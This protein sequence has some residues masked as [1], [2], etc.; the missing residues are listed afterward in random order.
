MR[1]FALLSILSSLA[2]VSVANPE[3]C[4]DH[5]GVVHAPGE[6]GT[7]QKIGTAAKLSLPAHKSSKSSKSSSS[8][9][10]KSSSKHKKVIKHAKNSA[11]AKKESTKPSHSWNH[12]SSDSSSP[13][14]KKAIPKV[15]HSSTKTVI[16]G[17]NKAVDQFKNATLIPSPL[18]SAL[19]EAVNQQLKPT[20]V[21]TITKTAAHLSTATSTV[22][23]VANSTIVKL[24]PT[25]I[26]RVIT[27]NVT[28][29]QTSTLIT[30]QES[31]NAALDI[32]KAIDSALAAANL[33]QSSL[34]ASTYASLEACLSTVL[35]SGGL[36]EGYSCLT[37]SGKDGSELESTLNTILEQFV[38]ILPNTILS[39]IFDSVTPLLTTLLPQ[40][41]QVLVNQITDSIQ[42]VIA[43][44]SGSS[45]TALEQVSSCYADAVK[46]AGNSSTLA[47]FTK[48]GGAASTLETASKSVLQQFVGVLP[49]SLTTAVE[50]ILTYNLANSSTP[51]QKL[52]GQVAAQISNAINSVSSALSGNTVT[53]AE[54]LQSCA[55]EL[56]ATGNATLAEQCIKDS[57]AP[58]ISQTT[59]LSIAQQFQ[60]YLP[61]SFF[62]DL[63]DYSTPYI[64][65][66]TANAHNLTQAQL[67]SEL[68]KFFNNGTSYGAQYVT[69]ISEV[70]QC[71]T[72]AIVKT[73]SIEAVCPGPVKGCSLA[74]SSSS[75]FAKRSTSSRFGFGG[76]IR[77]VTIY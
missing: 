19:A 72:N 47:C 57:K 74:K 32:K 9:S 67:N 8:S 68:E 59:M 40:S 69:C 7:P 62:T 33:T 56:I 23:Q 43:S 71:V 63:V 61:S 10:H 34:S 65:N 27:Q 11:T 18:A 53:L 50:N 20:N 52:A 21:A 2:L 4:S 5:P 75:R 73:G 36:P 45:V 39:A 48:P 14:K 41:E 13:K 44:L 51:D 66:F 3:P 1:S 22:T 76:S 42:S 16:D 49:A 30:S 17:A 58:Q 38:G 6:F 64:A 15:Q 26:V 31:I 55:S 70:Q 12:G 24:E 54:T 29:I 77:S 35:S 25:T 60:G 28:E 37:E 46:A